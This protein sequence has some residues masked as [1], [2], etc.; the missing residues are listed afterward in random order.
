MTDVFVNFRIGSYGVSVKQ[1][2]VKFIHTSYYCNIC[3]KYFIIM[4][5][6]V[7]YENPFPIKKIT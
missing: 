6:K 7:H 3:G 5:L 2:R 4:G 1:F